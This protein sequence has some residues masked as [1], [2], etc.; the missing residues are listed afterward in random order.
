VEI[1]KLMKTHARESD[2]VCRYGGEEFLLVIPGATASDASK[3]AEELRHKCAK[4]VIQH[5]GQAL[6]T[7]MSFGVSTYPTHDL[8]S[9]QIIIKADRALYQSK[10]S[11]RNRVTVWNESQVWR[12]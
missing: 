9:E 7:T 3:R 5:A 6:N 11:G 8:D 12:A 1:A 4:I 2:I 10:N